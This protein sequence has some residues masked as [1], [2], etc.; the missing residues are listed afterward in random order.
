MWSKIFPICLSVF[1][2]TVV[3]IAFYYNYASF[4]EVII[5]F[6]VALFTILYV[7]SFWSEADYFKARQ[8]FLFRK[9]EK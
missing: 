3:I 7:R 9:T 5:S 1:V 6:Q 4:G 2:Q 8:L